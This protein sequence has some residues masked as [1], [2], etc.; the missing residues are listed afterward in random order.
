MDY[1]RWD[2]LAAEEEREEQKQKQEQRVKNKQ[3]YL[4]QQEERVKQHQQQQ[5]QQQQ[6][7]PQP[8]SSSS[9]PSPAP[10][11][12]SH[13]D[14]P[15]QPDDGHDHE[16]HHHEHAP[17]SA[18]S[19]ASSERVDPYRRSCGCG[20]TDVATL[21]KMKEE[22]ERNPGP[23]VAEKNRKKVLA[24]QAVR[25]HGKLLFDEGKFQEALAVYERVSGR[26]QHSGQQQQLSAADRSH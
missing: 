7:P 19:S 13:P 9:S 25:E 6:S 8:S 4:K 22:A 5:Q 15:Q 3:D 24:V 1:S 11:S 2:A 14:G 17:N 10:H 12:H 21:M 20:M 23:S 26:R 18:S 16:H